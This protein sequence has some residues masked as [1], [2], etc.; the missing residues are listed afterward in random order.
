M[1][2]SPLSTESPLDLE[3]LRETLRAMSNKEL[4][5]F[6][7]EALDK[8]SFSVQVEEARAEVKRRKGPYYSREP[9]LKRR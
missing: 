5:K 4:L 3:Q 6:G 8:S 9:G 2:Q 7:R 1:A